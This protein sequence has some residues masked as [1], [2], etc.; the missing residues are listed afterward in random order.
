MV[1][2]LGVFNAVAG[3]V[4]ALLRPNI[5]RIVQHVRDGTMD[6]I[7]AKPLDPQSTCRSAAW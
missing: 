5:G 1:A 4:E 2:L 7:L 6:L 3:V